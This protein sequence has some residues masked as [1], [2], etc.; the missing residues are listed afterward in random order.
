VFQPSKA[1]HWNPDHI[2]FFKF[3]GRFVGKAIYDSQLL[4]AYFTRS[5]YKHMLG[6]KPTISDVE[7]I[8]PEYYK[9]L[10]WMLENSI[11]NVL[12]LEFTREGE[13]FG[14]KRVTELKKNGKNI[15]VTD[16]NKAEYVSL[17]AERMLTDDIRKQIDAFLEGFREIIDTKLLSIFNEQEL[18]LL[19]CGLPDIDINDL[20]AN[21]EYKGLNSSSEVISWFW[22]IVE[23]MTQEEK[24]LLVQFVTG[25]SKVPIQG[26]KELQGMNGI[27]RFQIHKASG[28][29]RLPT[30]HTCF[31]QL[32][33]PSYSSLKSMRKNLSL[34]IREGSEGFAFR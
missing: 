20:K 24:A 33:L 8:D 14:V 27:Q 4:D 28:K 30:A 2:Q 18:E 22:E 1:S 26:F 31:N 5:F 13:E 19:I 3:V 15:K 34:A 17:M 25:T 10:R 7:S 9:S 32:D 12:D 21:T 11:E 16:E 23:D 6:L 29:D